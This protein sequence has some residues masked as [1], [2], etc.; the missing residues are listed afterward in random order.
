MFLIK[1]LL[2]RVRTVELIP[3]PTI[4]TNFGGRRAHL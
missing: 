3:K 2:V 1:I 4:W